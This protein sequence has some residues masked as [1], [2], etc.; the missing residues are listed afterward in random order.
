MFESLTKT[1]GPIKAG[2][3][4]KFEFSYEGITIVN[5]SPQ[6][7]CTE[8]ANKNGKITGNYQSNPIPYHMK[9]KQDSYTARKEI[10]VDY[11]ETNPSKVLRT[12]LTIIVHVEDK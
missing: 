10:Y 4:Q 3:I 11:Y 5:V 7:G 6:C 1:Y 8:V 12:T 2:Q 9:A